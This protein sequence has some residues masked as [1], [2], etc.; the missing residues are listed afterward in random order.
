MRT[1]HTLTGL[2]AAALIV[3][4]APAASAAP[5]VTIKVVQSAKTATVS[6]TYKGAVPAS[7]TLTVA[8][9]VD[10]SVTLDPLDALLAEPV[11][12]TLKKSARSYKV[13]DLDT[14]SKYTFTLTSRKPTIKVSRTV[15][16]VGKPTAPSA[17][18]LTWNDDDLIASW[19]YDGPAVRS[20]EVAAA[21]S[22]NKEPVTVKTG[23]SANTARLK[24][25]DKA[26]GYTVTVRGVNAA[27]T[28]SMADETILQVAPNRPS[29]LL[30]RPIQL[31]GTKVSLSWE[32]DGPAVTGFRVQIK[33]PGYS[34][35]LDVVN[36]AGDARQV[37][38]DGL[39]AGGTYVFGV[40][41][42]NSQATASST[43]DPYVVAKVL[44]APTNLTSTPANAAV[45][46]K[47][48]APVADPANPLTG[49]R[50]EYSSDN[51][52]SWRAFLG[53]GTAVTYTVTGLAN[54]ESYQ[55]RVSALTAKFSGMSS[56]VITAVAGQV[57]AVP[58]GVKVVGGTRQIT[59][60]WTAP[61]VSGG[62]IVAYKVEYKKSTDTAWT[63]SADVTTTNALIIGLEGGVVYNARVAAVGESGQGAFSSSASGTA[64]DVPA[65]PVL[66]VTA[67]N[68]KADLSW[69]APA[70]N[71]STITGYKIEQ[72]VGEGVWSAVTTNAVTVT[73][74]SVANLVPGTTYRF[75]VYAINAAGNGPESAPQTAAIVAAPDAP[76]VTATPAAGQ[77]ILSWNE[78]T[79]NGGSVSAYKIER[80]ASGGTW[81]VLS[82]T[83]TS[84]SASL[85]YT[86][87]GLTNGTQYSFRVS[88]RN[89][90]G[91]STPSTAVAATPVTVPVA[92]TNVIIEPNIEEIK[93]RWSAIAN[94]ASSTGGSAITG[95]VVSYRVAGGTWAVAP[96]GSVSGA[97]LSLDVSDL[98][99]GTTY[100]FRV[101]A[102]NTAG[103]GP[104]SV[105]RSGVP[106]AAPTA[107][108]DLSAI[109]SDRKVTLRWSAPAQSISGTVTS[110]YTY[111]VE[112]TIDGNTWLLAKDAL[113]DTT[114][115]VT[116]L[117]NGTPYRFRVS[118]GY[119]VGGKTSYGE[120]AEI[121]ATPRGAPGAPEGLR[122]TQLAGGTS[123]ELTW[124][125]PSNTGGG[126]LGD[127]EISYTSNGTTWLPVPVLTTTGLSKVVA[128]L[129][130]GL[131]Y[132][133]RVRVTS[134]FGDSAYSTVELTPLRAPSAV[135]G[136]SVRQVANGQV[137]LGWNANTATERVE[138]YRIE[139]TFGGTNVWTL[140]T[141]S[142]KT[143][144]ATVTGL[145]NGVAYSFR[146]AAVNVAGAG[147]GATTSG[148]PTGPL[149]VSGLTANAA[150]SKITLSWTLPSGGGATINGVR[151]RYSTD[152]GAN[153]SANTDL[154]ASATSKEFTGLTNSTEYLFE[155]T[156][157][158]NVG[159]SEARMVKATP[160]VQLPTAVQNLSAVATATSV[161]VD[162]DVPATAGVG[163]L[164][165]KVEYKLV[166]SAN[167]TVATTGLIATEYTISA[168]TAS[169]DYEFRVTS[170]NAA[171]DG[172]AVTATATTGA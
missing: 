24:G 57:P 139:Y 48:V 99:A 120:V 114:T 96:G 133:F 166:A 7:Q 148:T 14:G 111:K 41:A 64:I 110:K 142:E 140:F 86:A 88:A 20:W 80:S 30:V 167:W 172:P 94:T 28:G 46:L 121:S 125:A 38:I 3:S 52:A 115:D 157:L 90:T 79:V 134:S 165:Y 16:I 55:F 42:R 132:T 73:T 126:L 118:A 135:T 83:F 131:P 54:G 74:Y 22:D 25:L 164:R 105:A 159:N 2:L 143:T 34:R 127:Y 100:E 109:G 112:Y 49:Y 39:T 27:G 58:S 106:Y 26:L 60:S 151:I 81:T 158:T 92:V 59:V 161:L 119:T 102:V 66:T 23:S 146:V 155:V 77:V 78:P 43:T 69:K 123:V 53:Q 154:A 9:V 36:A 149:P 12:Y 13:S 162:W 84:T 145:T 44:A 103:T 33:A 63:P 144:L 98:T 8:K 113:S 29:N 75:R 122:A 56:Q 150:D 128:D 138:N 87:S 61:Q 82:D 171:G 71:G 137:T 108:T 147:P 93:V 160:V 89:S 6:W 65:A 129:T 97:T 76:V 68:R 141:G 107:P 5:S 32:Y 51:G 95:Y 136:L 156:V 17:L 170:S 40:T 62:T 153:W 15:S 104:D 19:T 116:L 70:N 117:T 45:N 37:E 47:W 169:S 124:A 4:L 72:Q 35:N 101:A 50:I 152:S 163:S 11:T 91:W 10:P 168:L 21:G 67:G 85:T 31:D 18:T 130:A 1:R